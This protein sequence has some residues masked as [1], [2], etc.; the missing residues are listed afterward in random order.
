MR[1]ALLE[2]SP[3]VWRIAC[4]EMARR[5]QGGSVL[6]PVA[7]GLLGVGADLHRTSPGA[8]AAL[9]AFT[10]LLA[11]SRLYLIRRFDSVFSRFPRLWQVVFFGGALASG[12]LYSGLLCFV[13]LEKGLEPFA[14]FALAAN[15]GLAAVVTVTYPHSK[16]VVL[17]YILVLGVPPTLALAQLVGTEPSADLLAWSHGGA[18]LYLLWVGLQQH[19]ER[20]SSLGRRIHL[21]VRSADLER[22]HVEVQQARAELEVQVAERTRELER[23]SRDYRQI[24]ENAHDPIIVF[25]PEDERVLNVNRRACEIYGFTR[26]EF[27]QISLASISVDAARGQRQVLET[28]AGGVYHNFESVQY[29]KDGSRMF[30]EI[31]AAT[32]EYEGRPAIISINRDVTERRRAEALRLAKE[33]AERTARAKAQ[34]LA[35]MSHEIRTPMAGVIG[36]SDLLLATDLDERQSQYARLIQSSTGSL[37][38][39]IDDILDFSKIEAGK[40][41]FE[42]VPFDL[43]ATLGEVVEILRL[44]AMAKGTTLE[45]F[46]AEDLPGWVRGDPGRLRQVLMN[47]VG[48]AVKFTEGGSVS[49]QADTAADGRVRVQVK[50][51]GIGIPRDAQGRLFELFS[52][53]D[54]STSRRFGGT[55]L[56]LAIS[57]RI[58][59]AMGGE[60]GFESVKGR[61]ST[62]WIRLP[63]APGAPPAKT[64]SA[65]HRPVNARILTVEDNPINQVVITEHLKHLGYRVTAVGN[66]LEALEAL[67]VEDYDLVLMDCQMPHLDGYEATERIRLLPGKTSQIPIVALTAHAIKEEL[68]R[69]LAVGMNDYITKPFRSQEL[70]AKLERWLGNGASH[71]SESEPAPSPAIPAE[72]AEAALNQRQLESLRAMCKDSG[73]GFVA[74]L[75]EQFRRQPYL[76]DL[77]TALEHGD[78]AL[79]RARAHGLKGTS[80]LLGAHSLPRLCEELERSCL[81]ASRED[82]LRQ[83]DQIDAEHRRFVVRLVENLP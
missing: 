45:L 79:L 73:P 50:D 71:S 16:P 68:D 25:R 47:L 61:G 59:E 48:N 77:R 67:A 1:Q 35:N 32:V 51:S 9:V 76:E 81:L 80:S 4:Q 2:R 43:R 38:R 53:G 13:T 60:I 55:G 52:Q 57:K 74:G 44:A 70:Q 3:E 30:L 23:T 56:G 40:L 65:V 21:E 24:F 62:F 6:Y 7:I 46:A 8:L 41:A 26:E 27:L 14:V 64:E 63:L 82:C 49:V 15:L 22:A 10:M 69:C 11:L 72:P 17:S 58:V 36:L 78:R 83:L 54:D 18:T 20:W 39:V 34:F 31:N 19:R 37:L 5:A 75:V 28:L 33:A 66:G 29:R 12:A 42:D